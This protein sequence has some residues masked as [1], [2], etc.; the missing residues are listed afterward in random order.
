MTIIHDMPEA[1]YHA[2]SALGNTDIGIIRNRSPAHYIARKAAPDKDTPAK[3]DGRALHC[4]ILEPGKFMQRYSV[5]PSNAPRDLRHLRDAAKPSDSTRASI[6]WWDNFDAANAGR[7]LLMQDDYD[8]KMRVA[9]AVRE[10]PELKGYFDA[11]GGQSEVSV[12][13]TDPETGVGVKCRQDYR[14]QL[15]GYTVVLDPKST[16]DARAANFQ[17]SAW[18]YNYFQQNAFY[19]DVSEWADAKIDLFLFIAFEKEAPYGVKVYEVAEQDIEFGRRSYR[20]GLNIAAECYRTGIWPIYDE[21]IEVLTR[22]G[23]AKD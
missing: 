17:K 1:E 14:V 22:P 15:G 10:H 3:L 16:E 6:A 5:A 7:I 11:P 12:F 13:A 23:W 9:D 21:G 19:T 4:A 18:N 8:N 20:E 2:H